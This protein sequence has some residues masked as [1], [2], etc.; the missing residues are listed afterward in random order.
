MTVSGLMLFGSAAR[1]DIGPDS[2]TDLLAISRE[3]GP[4]SHKVNGIEIQFYS[5]AHLLKMGES[6]DLFAIHLARE[7]R[8]IFDFESV[9]A[10]FYQI[11]KPRDNYERE[12]SRAIDLA[13]YLLRFGADYDSLLVNRRIAWCVRTTLISILADRGQYVF[14]PKG[15]VSLFPEPCVSRLI[16][17]RRSDE[18]SVDRFSWLRDFLSE[19]SSAAG[20][21]RT[22]KEFVEHFKLTGNDVAISTLK[23]LRR[24][25]VTS[26]QAS[27][28]TP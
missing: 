12:R 8:V 13:W 24:G 17:L 14:S 2:D 5:P 22:T 3:G 20:G 7:G 9:F 18:D 23:R 6:G 19:F 26:Q 21:Q 16:A 15:L 28:Y 4:R 1:G 10:T 25:K 11:T 27:T